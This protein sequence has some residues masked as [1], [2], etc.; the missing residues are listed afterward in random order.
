MVQKTDIYLMIRGG[1]LKWFRYVERIMEG[2]LSEKESKVG[3]LA[4]RLESEMRTRFYFL[5][6]RKV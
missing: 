2:L 4:W 1:T 5:E 3:V 6:T